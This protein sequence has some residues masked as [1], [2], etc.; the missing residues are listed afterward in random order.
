VAD[1]SLLW[2]GSSRSDVR[3]FPEG[4]RST[5]GFQLRRIQQGLDPNDWKPMP[6]VGPGVREVRIHVEGEHRVFY[7]ASFPEAV[8]V[9]HAFEKKAR[10]TAVQD[11]ELGR[12]RFR[13]LV[14]MRRERGSK[15]RS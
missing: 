5:V 10:R 15:E 14:K 11:L 7:V 1:K 6:T 13:D 9:L 3:A 8:Y 12:K 2:L 4:A